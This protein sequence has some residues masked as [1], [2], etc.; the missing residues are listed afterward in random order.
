MPSADFLGT[1]EPVFTFEY[2]LMFSKLG[3]DVLKFT[4]SITLPKASNASTSIPYKNY[5]KAIAGTNTHEV[6]TLKVKS[7]VSPNTAAKLWEWYKKVYPKKGVLGHPK[8]YKDNGIIALTDGQS[9]PISTWKV[10]GAWPSKI[11]MGDAGE[12][13]NATN[14]MIGLTLDIDDFEGPN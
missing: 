7:F 5:V 3:D 2:H 6:I 8:D 1:S 10:T 4:E 11:D 14:I 12:G 13:A 9:N